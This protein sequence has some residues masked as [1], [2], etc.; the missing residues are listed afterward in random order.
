[1]GGGAVSGD[2]V[3]ITGCGVETAGETAVED[4]DLAGT[5]G[6]S[7]AALPRLRRRRWR[8]LRRVGKKDETVNIWRPAAW[9]NTTRAFKPLADIGRIA[10]WNQRL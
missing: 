7:V 10:P 4:V 1:M 6:A 8:Q 3:G 2:S 5:S 9:L